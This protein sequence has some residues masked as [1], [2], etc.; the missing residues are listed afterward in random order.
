MIETARRIYQE[1]GSIEIDDNAKVSR[2]EGNPDKGAYVQ[3][4]LWVYDESA[5]ENKNP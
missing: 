2:G 5:K 1:E 3:A 4:W